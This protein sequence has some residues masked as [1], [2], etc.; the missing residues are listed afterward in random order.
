MRVGMRAFVELLKQE[1]EKQ[2]GCEVVTGEMK[3][4]H[5]GNSYHGLLV[6][7]KEDRNWPLLFLDRIVVDYWNGRGLE[8]IVEEVCL[9]NEKRKTGNE[10][11][12]YFYEL[13]KSKPN[14]CYQLV[15]RQNTL[16]FSEG[17]LQ[18]FYLDLVKQYGVLTEEKKGWRIFLDIRN[19]YLE[20]WGISEQ[21]LKQQAEQNMKL[22][23]PVR[24]KTIR[25]V[26][27]GKEAELDVFLKE[28]KGEEQAEHWLTLTNSLQFYGAT[29]MTY[30]GVLEE[31][32]EQW[33]DHL[34]ISPSSVHEITVRPLKRGYGISTC[35]EALQER[36]LTQREPEEILSNHIYL[37]ER[38]TGHLMVV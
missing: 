33:D 19:S 17:K 14:F 9:E 38:G 30:E 18:E 15:N 4:L 22:L 26:F 20:R 24:K 6:L 25:E 1:L 2:T 37:Y 31:I 27:P 23:L 29:V 32:A 36:N 21:E 34:V 10:I 3:R 5:G 35:I 8:S 13:E 7:G 28:I 16:A 11:G 12:S